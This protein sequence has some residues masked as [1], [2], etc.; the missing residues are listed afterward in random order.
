MAIPMKILKPL[1]RL[2]E[3]SWVKGDYELIKRAGA[4]RPIGE[5]PN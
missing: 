5:E 3:V 1:Y 2:A 4:S